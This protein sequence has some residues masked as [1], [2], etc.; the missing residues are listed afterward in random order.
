MELH[1]W[2]LG[3]LVCCSGTSAYP[4]VRSVF[5]LHTTPRTWNEAKLICEA[6][7]AELFRVKNGNTIDELKFVDGMTEWNG[8]FSKLMS[9]NMMW[10]ALYETQDT[11]NQFLNHGCIKPSDSFSWPWAVSQPTNLPNQEFCVAMDSKYQWSLQNCNQTYNFICQ[12]ND[13][14]CWFDPRDNTI[15]T[16]QTLT[17]EDV[18]VE[19]EADCATSCRNGWI[20]STE[21]WG[22]SYRVSDNTCRVHYHTDSAIF[23][24]NT[25][26]TLEVNTDWT[27]YAKI[28]VGG[29]LRSVNVNYIDNNVEPRVLNCTDLVTVDDVLD[30]AI[31]YCE[32][33]DP[34]PMWEP[35]ISSLSLKQKIEQ[36]V[37]ALTIDSKNTSAAQRKLISVMDDRP[38]SQSIGYIGVVFLS[39]VFGS[40]II[41]DLN[42]LVSHTN[43][44]VKKLKTPTSSNA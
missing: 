22:F 10:L 24:N 15:A 21:C 7:S 25:S 33:R 17:I 40:I 37:A 30:D 12:R 20:N 23:I 32:C 42:V 27:F 44:L 8:N 11:A 5:Y 3:I 16:A 2:L 13:G 19:S 39:L 26:N 36:I 18:V 29:L 6:Q 4:S 28:C 14:D 35:T 1:V 41:L 38:S 9:Q 31:C 43:N 34:P